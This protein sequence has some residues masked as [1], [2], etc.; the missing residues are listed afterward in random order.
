MLGPGSAAWRVWPCGVRA[1]KR[2]RIWCGPVRLTDACR[3]C[4]RKHSWELNDTVGHTDIGGASIDHWKPGA[5]DCACRRGG[6]SL[7]LN[8]QEGPVQ[9]QL[10]RT[11]EV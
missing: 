1:R 5:G 8:L 10:E 11:D 6:R 3:V 4:Y 2:A 9:H 7:P